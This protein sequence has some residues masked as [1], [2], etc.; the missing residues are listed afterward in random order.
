MNKKENVKLEEKMDQVLF[1]L[2]KITG[3]ESKQEKWLNN[4]ETCNILNI[5]VRTLQNYRDKGLIS[6]SQIGSKIYYKL[7]DI[8]EFLERHYNKSYTSIKN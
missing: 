2:G 5:S 7:T 8:H 4:P 6:F 3:N 1:K